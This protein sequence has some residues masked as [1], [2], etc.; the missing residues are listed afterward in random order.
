MPDDVH[1]QGLVNDPVPLGVK[2]QQEKLIIIVE[3]TNKIY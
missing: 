3:L 2:N 1:G